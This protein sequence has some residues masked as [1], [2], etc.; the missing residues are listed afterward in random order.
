MLILLL[1]AC[2][3]RFHKTE[4]AKYFIHITLLSVDPKFLLCV[5]VSFGFFFFKK[6]NSFSTEI[7]RKK[8]KFNS[9]TEVQE[10]KKWKEFRVSKFCSS[11]DEAENGHRCRQPSS[12]L[13][14][15]YELRRYRQRGKRA[16]TTTAV[17]RW[18]ALVDST[19][20]GASICC[21]PPSSQRTESL[22]I[23]DRIRN[24]QISVVWN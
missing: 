18:P 16:L 3:L 19:G 4:N 22:K 15:N 5:S 9:I 20:C 11:G 2:V 14:R 24:F 23:S 13:R 1:R 17:S 10:E 7:L 8:E 12:G 21:W 6:Q